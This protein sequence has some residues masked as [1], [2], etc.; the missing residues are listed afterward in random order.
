MCLYY[1]KKPAE[2]IA[3][4]FVIK[5][6]VLSKPTTRKSF[7]DFITHL[8]SSSFCLYVMN[9]HCDE[10]ER[11][12]QQRERRNTKNGNPFSAVLPAHRAF[13]PFSNQIHTR[14]H[15]QSHKEG[16]CQAEYDRP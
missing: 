16:E 15:N 12:K 5:H 2:K 1:K 7:T 6:F 10:H 4:F 13:E 8:S 14:H 11:N 9:N 3:D